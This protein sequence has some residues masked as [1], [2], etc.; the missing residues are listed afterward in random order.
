MKWKQV[1]Y[2]GLV[3]MAGIAA[4]AMAENKGAEEMVLQGGASG[5][6]AFPHHRHQNALADCNLCHAQ[7]PQTAGAVEGL[8]KDG[9][10][11]KKA[12][13]NACVKCHR[14][15]AKEGGKTGP[16]SCK[17]CHNIKG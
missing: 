17:Q 4:M 2:G 11:A 7:F 15:K 12:V 16:T 13:M 6:V 3:L 14:Q 10:L 8:K 5:N 9:K 1:I